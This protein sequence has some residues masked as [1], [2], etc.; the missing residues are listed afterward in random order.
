MLKTVI[1]DDER[2]ARKELKRILE[3]YN[4]QIEVSGEAS[5][6]E[7]AVAVIDDLQPDLV[8]LD[9]QMP[10][11]NGFELLEDLDFAPEVIFITAYDD[12]AIKAFEVDALDY[13]LKPIDE[14]RFDEALK[15]VLAKIE[16]KQA[17]AEE[18]ESSK[19]PQL[20]GNDQVFLKDGDKC[21]LVQLHNVR[22]FESEGNYIRVYFEDNKPLILKSLNNLDKKLSDR[23]FFRANRKHIIN[24]KWI[25]KVET[26]FNGGLLVILQDG[27]KVEV[28]RRQAVKFKD[29]LSL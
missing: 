9:I 18:I 2:L 29:M 13:I 7:E 4:K 27:Q 15:K 1:V 8:F 10:G 26:W 6:A 11:K 20:T 16:L 19:Q 21:W 22:L 14:E 24:L 25:E 17:E 5:N 12:Y 28:S 3:K 23:D